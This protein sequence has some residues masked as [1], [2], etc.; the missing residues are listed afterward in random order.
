V[1][2]ND[3]VGP[4]LGQV[5]W[6][7]TQRGKHAEIAQASKGHHLVTGAQMTHRQIT[8]RT[9]LYQIAGCP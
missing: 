7:L 5:H 6:L 9:R 3:Q 4:E 2:M 1:F 8:D